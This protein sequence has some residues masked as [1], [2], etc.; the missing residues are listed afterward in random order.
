MIF[1]ALTLVLAQLNQ[2]IHQADGNPAGTTDPVILGNISQIDNPSI[3]A[4]LENKVVLTLVN[5]SEEGT[6]KND[7]A[8]TRTSSGHINYHNPPIYLNLNLLFSANYT[9]YDTALK[10]L[11]QVIT[12][13]QGKNKFTTASSTGSL[14]NV[15]PVAD[16]SLTIDL[17]T[18]NL[19][20]INH[21]WG[22]LGGK[23]L[24]SAVFCGRLVKIQDQR[25]LESGGSIEEIDISGKEVTL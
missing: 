25:I 10:R 18:L 2:H 17:M 13:F 19:E 3:A 12:F 4:N 15:S 5:L 22:F 14:Q 20:E 7:Q 6:L 1:E 23:Q 16:I 8:Y 24:P 11:T 9:N 21:I